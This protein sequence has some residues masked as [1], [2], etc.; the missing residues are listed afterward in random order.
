MAITN[1]IGRVELA[2][3]T[4]AILHGLLCTPPAASHLSTK[5]RTCCTLSFT[6]TTHKGVF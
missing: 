6:A 5:S 2:A 1:T 4:A 3:I